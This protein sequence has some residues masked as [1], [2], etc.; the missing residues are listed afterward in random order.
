LE[1]EVQAPIRKRAAIHFKVI[2]V[3]RRSRQA[4]STF[5]ESPL[6]RRANSVSGQ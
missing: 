2:G 6:R 5:C 1:S 4:I 3:S